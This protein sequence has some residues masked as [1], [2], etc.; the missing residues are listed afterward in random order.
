M[1]SHVKANHDI[2]MSAEDGRAG[3]GVA[4]RIGRWSGPS[5]NRTDPAD[6]RVSLENQPK[7]AGL[8]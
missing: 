7:E 4:G 5:Q 6:L 3:V 8:C 2:D 1:Q